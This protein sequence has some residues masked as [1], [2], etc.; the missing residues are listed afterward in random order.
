MTG[1]GLIQGVSFAMLA[2]LLS[3]FNMF[4]EKAESN[5]TLKTANPK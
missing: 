2:L 3:G 4:G 5:L 1:Q